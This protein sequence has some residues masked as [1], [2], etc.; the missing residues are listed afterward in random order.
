[1]D[2]V[3]GTLAAT[4]KRQESWE[5]SE[6]ESWSDHEKEVTGENLLRPEILEL[7]TQNV[8]MSPAVV[9]HMGKVCS[10]VRKTHGR[11][12]T[13]D[14]DDLDV[15]TAIWCFFLS[16][17]LQAAVHL[18]RDHMENLRFTKN[19]P[20]KSVKQLFL[21]TEKL[22]EDQTEINNLTTIDYKE[23]S[24]R[25]TSSLCDKAFEITNTKTYVFA[26][27]CSVWEAWETNRS[28]PGR[29]KFNGIWNIAISKM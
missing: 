16:V 4:E 18:G 1:M 22:I 7:Q 21:V 9:P 28:K 5:F 29:T 20:L 14:L 26:D 19:Q 3:A 8:H 2:R 27:S 6:S 15:N 11:S 10:V 23:L 17:T 24:W 13:D 25:S 12:P